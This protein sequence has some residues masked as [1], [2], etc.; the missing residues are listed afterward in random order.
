[1]EIDRNTIGGFGERVRKNLAFMIAAHAR[2]DDV[3]IVTELTTALLGVIVFPYAYLEE[4]QFIDFKKYRLNVLA[5]DGWPVWTFH[6]GSS[7]HLHDH[8]RHLRN[9]LSHRRIDFSSNDRV[10]KKV[11]IMFSD[12]PN[13]TKKEPKPPINWSATINGAA[14]LDFTLRLAKLIDQENHMAG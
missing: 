6:F 14:L 8:L 11:E 7:T 3:H 4:K 5:A 13:S 1:M 2:G 12:R 9:A 10:L